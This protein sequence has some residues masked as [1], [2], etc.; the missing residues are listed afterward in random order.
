M[1]NDVTLDAIGT[2]WKEDHG[3]EIAVIK[4]MTGITSILASSTL[5]WMILRSHVG[6]SSTYHRLLMGLSIC[7]IIYSF[8]E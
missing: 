6:F 4:G 1:Y 3:K 7:D 5:I 2:E 8:S